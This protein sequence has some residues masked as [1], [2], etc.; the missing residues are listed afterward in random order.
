MAGSET[1]AVNRTAPTMHL[2]ASSPVSEGCFLRRNRGLNKL[3]PP[4][5]RAEKRFFK[6]SLSC[7]ARRE[8]PHFSANCLKTFIV[9]IRH[10]PDSCL[11][12]GSG[13]CD[14]HKIPHR[15]D[16]LGICR[17]HWRRVGRNGVGGLASGVS[18]AIGCALVQAVLVPVLLPVAIVRMVVCL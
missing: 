8:W 4:V 6:P 5:R 3:C 16:L 10:W 17:R 15:T 1:I 12:F 2:M 9:Q 13:I 11:R 14:A 7:L 18:G